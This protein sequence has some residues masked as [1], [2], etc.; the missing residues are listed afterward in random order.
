MTNIISDDLYKD[1]MAIVDRG[2]E[3]AAREFL[4]SHLKEFPQETQDAIIMAFVEEALGKSAEETKLIADFQKQGL[5]AIDELEKSKQ[6]LEDKKKMLEL[7][8]SM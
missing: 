8:E 2:D 6:E 5:A 3:K 7:K 4:V 1:F